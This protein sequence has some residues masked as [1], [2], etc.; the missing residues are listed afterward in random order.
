MSRDAKNA[1]S[2]KCATTKES[3]DSQAFRKARLGFKSPTIHEILPLTV[4][5]VQNHKAENVYN[6]ERI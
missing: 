3:Y 6:G 5:T 4:R 1:K 2:R